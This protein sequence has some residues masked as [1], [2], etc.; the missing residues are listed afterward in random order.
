MPLVHSIAGR[1]ATRLSLPLFAAGLLACSSNKPAK[2]VAAGPRDPH[3]VELAVE[4]T[5]DK[6]V[7]A[8]VAELAVRI[9]VSAAHLPAGDRPPINLTLVLDTSGSM[10]G[11]AIASARSAAAGMVERLTAR[12]RV[13][14]VVFNST[15]EVLVAST[16]VTA[17]ARA[18]IAAAIATIRA[19][20]T[21]DMA[22]GLALGL[23]QAAAGR[24]PGSIDRIVLLGDG[25]PN[26]GA[27]LPGLVAQ[28]QAQHLPIT[29]LGLGV[30]FDPQL[31]GRIATDTGA[32]YHYLDEADQ[33][34][35]VFDQELIEMRQVV[36]KNL[37]LSLVP[38]PGVTLEPMAGF[39]PAGNGLYAVLGDLGAGEMRDVIVP[40][41]VVGRRPGATVE[42]MDATL[43]FEDATNG[44]GAL[45]R[46]GFAKVK[47]DD[48]REAVAASIKVQI[49]VARARAR[50]ASAIL[51]AIN[52]ARAGDLDGARGVLDEAEAQARATAATSGD[53]E[54]AALA[55]Q[56]VALR[57]DLAELAAAAMA[58]LQFEQS[59]GAGVTAELPAAAAPPE[60]PAPSPAHRDAV[61]RRAR[62]IEARA[63]DVMTGR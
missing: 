27:P 42:I 52:R 12:D 59:A 17:K 14:L 18:D 54:L 7:A 53:A 57:D 26:D 2:Q 56:M 46:S 34:A 5:A 51:E 30:E 11:D 48:D 55:E 50:A 60:A 38:G 20:G 8:E 22:S 19:R 33:V 13:S 31:L 10:E 4:T 35:T 15:A 40:L 49:E 47:A 58:Q 32:R 37:A 6:V 21:T 63:R 36:G 16:Q 23:Q 43:T 62:A 29:T 44:A 45:T 41:K 39:Q 25:V 3:L 61:E 24:S 28:A 1:V 9:R